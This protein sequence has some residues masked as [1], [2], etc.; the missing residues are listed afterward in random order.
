[1]HHVSSRRH[2]LARRSRAPAA[3]PTP[4]TMTFPPAAAPTH[5]IR[6]GYPAG[7]RPRR[8]RILGITHA[9]RPELPVLGSDAGAPGAAEVA[10]GE[11]V[12]IQPLGDPDERSHGHPR[13]RPRPQVT[14][15]QHHFE[16]GFDV[17]T[18]DLQ[19]LNGI[20]Y[21]SFFLDFFSHIFLEMEVRPLQFFFSYEFKF[22]W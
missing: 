4:R 11:R 15:L 5:R 8:W 9:F 18:L 13:R 21:R 17:D 20:Y 19:V 7:A 16:A 12:A 3:V 6:C 10:H 1:M 22:C 14:G 2:P